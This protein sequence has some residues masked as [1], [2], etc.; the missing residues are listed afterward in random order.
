MKGW[1]PRDVRAFVALLF[2]VLGGIALTGVLV[3]LAYLI[4]YGS[5]SAATEQVRAA[6]LVRASHI[7]AVGVVVVMIA[8]GWAINRRRI[9]GRIGGERG[10]SFN[11]EGGDEAA[12]APVVT[13]TTSTTVAPT[14]SGEGV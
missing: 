1:P 3:F 5:W 14:A 4:A 6:G 11:M 9:E 7:V 13:T 10:A 2:S 12:P 8:L